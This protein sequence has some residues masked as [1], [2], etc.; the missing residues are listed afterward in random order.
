M[1]WHADFSHLVRERAEVP[2][3]ANKARGRLEKLPYPRVLCSAKPR[4]T[5][6]IR[7]V[8]AGIMSHLC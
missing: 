1:Q 2:S 7:K 3:V 8:D 5:L 4:H 6:R